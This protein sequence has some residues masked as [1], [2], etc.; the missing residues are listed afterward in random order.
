MDG[1]WQEI[2]TRHRSGTSKPIKRISILK[3]VKIP[4]ICKRQDGFP[5][6][7]QSS[8]FFVPP[9][10]PQETGTEAVELLH[11]SE[12]GYCMLLKGHCNDKIIVYKVLKED[13]RNDP[14]SQRLLRREYEIAAPLH[15]PGICQTLDWVTLPGYGDAIQMEWINGIPLNQWI[16]EHPGELSRRRKIL[17]DLCD[18]LS[19]LHRKQVIHKDLKP[20]NILVTSSGDYPKIID[21]GLS[22]ADAILTGKAPGG[23]R[24]YAAPEVEAGENADAL[25]DIYSLGVIMQSMGPAFARIARKCASPERGKRYVSAE[26]VRQDLEKMRRRKTEAICVPIGILA[27]ALGLWMLLH[28]P[29]PVKELFQDAVEQVRQA[30]NPS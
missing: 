24:P 15:H 20:E 29:D 9:P 21:F 10:P 12:D 1:D 4:Y 13:F 3:L 23:T 8:G 16:E 27:A 28:R 22:D 30:A 26:E 14:V 17:T 19:Y 25:S 18:A 6:M 5:R 11:T 2:H 7:I